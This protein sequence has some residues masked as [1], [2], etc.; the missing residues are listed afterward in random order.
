MDRPPRQ[1][2]MKHTFLALAAGILSGLLGLA[3]Q[4]SAS[5]SVT[6]LSLVLPLPILM[7]GLSL[8]TRAAAIAA[9]IGALV[10]GGANVYAGAMFALVHGLPVWLL[11]RLALTGPNGPVAN[12]PE[13][14]GPQAPES[15]ETSSTFKDRIVGRVEDW[16]GESSEPPRDAGWYPAGFVL[17][18]VALMAAAGLLIAEAA[19]GW[20]LKDAVHA[21][22]NQFF[23]AMGGQQAP[24]ALDKAADLLT[25]LFPGVTVG[26][27]AVLLV[28]NA[29]IAQALLARGGRHIRPSPR[30]RE[31]KLPE[32][33]SWPLVGAAVL[34]LAGSGEVEYLGRNMA[35]VFAVPYFFLGLAVLHK[36]ASLVPFPGMLVAMFYMAMLTG[37][38]ILVVAAIGL[39]EQWVGLKKRFNPPQKT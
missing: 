17:A 26:M 37:W 10:T 18:V 34:A 38:F 15:R 1:T 9:A 21:M 39:L 2:G 16:E 24:E 14:T 32:W 31:L 35:L 29:A 25:P 7:A 8:G 19:T 33:L 4:S 22:L 30:L 28:A 23:S 36:M 3:S 6:Y 5:F 11:V 20:A 27:W 13:R 12:I